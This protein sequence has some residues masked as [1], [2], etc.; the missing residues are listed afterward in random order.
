MDGKTL[1]FSTSVAAATTISI[2]VCVEATRLLD[3]DGKRLQ[4]K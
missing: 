2:D 3:D 1:Y 4:H